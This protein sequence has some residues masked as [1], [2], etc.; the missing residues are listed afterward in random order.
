MPNC[1]WTGHRTSTAELPISP[2]QTHFSLLPVLAADINMDPL[3]KQK[4]LRV[5]PDS[6]SHSGKFSR[7]PLLS[8]R[9][10]I[11]PGLSSSSS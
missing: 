7:S 3:T 1:L 11:A 6:F 10:C 2:P 4:T 8:Q 9:A 5:I